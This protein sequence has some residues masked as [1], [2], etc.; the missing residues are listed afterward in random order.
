MAMVSG[1]AASPSSTALSAEKSW[2][3]VQTC[4]LKK[5][6]LTWRLLCAFAT[7][8][9]KKIDEAEK[10]FHAKVQ[11]RKGAKIPSSLLS[12]N[13]HERQGSD[14]MNPLM[15]VEARAGC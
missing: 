2:L 10:G 15:L 4:G 7:L 9:E 8:R 6:S 5:V 1:I 12:M 13:W 14:S 11:R 3:T